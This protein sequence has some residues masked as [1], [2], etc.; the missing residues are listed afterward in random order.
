MPRQRDPFKIGSKIKRRYEIEKKV[1]HGGFAVVYRAHDKELRRFVAIKALIDYGNESDN[2]NSKKRFVDEARKLAEI[3]NKKHV[4]EV[5]DKGKHTKV[6]YFVMEFVP[7]SL[8]DILDEFDDGPV[9]PELT[10]KLLRQTLEGLAEVHDRG[11]THRDIKPNNIL[12]TEDEEV[13]LADFGII[14]DPDKSRTEYGANPGTRDWMAP[15]QEEGYTVTP[16]TDVYAFG[17]VAFLMISGEQ[18]SPFNSVDLSKFTDNGTSRLVSQCLEEEPSDRPQDARAVLQEWDEIQENILKKRPRRPIRGDALV[19]NVRTRI[20]TEYG[21][22]TGSVKLFYPSS[23]RPVR[24][25][26]KISRV[27]NKWEA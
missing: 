4:V 15:E 6:P 18:W 7:Y 10:I 17:L 1:G 25:D 21:L 20:E 14:K 8:V 12:L 19:R 22:P 2:S 23:T 3:T 27:R 24:A 26:V 9:D 16:R 11:W 5:H 13:K